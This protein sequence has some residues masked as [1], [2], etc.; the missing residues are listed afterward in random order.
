MRYRERNDRGELALLLQVLVRLPL[1]LVLRLAFGYLINFN[2]LHK[3]RDAP[4]FAEGFAR[5]RFASVIDELITLH[6][7]DSFSASS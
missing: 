5:L 2:A 6:P 7:G 1:S 4:S 3:N